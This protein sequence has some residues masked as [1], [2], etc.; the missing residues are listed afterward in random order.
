M[1][2]RARHGG[3]LKQKCHYCSFLKSGFLNLEFKVQIDEACN[4]RYQ[5]RSESIESSMTCKTQAALL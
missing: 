5:R 3:R 2:L 4:L 1:Q